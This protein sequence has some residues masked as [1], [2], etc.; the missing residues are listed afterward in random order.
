MSR[1][2][3]WKEQEALRLNKVKT[4]LETLFIQEK[5][6]FRKKLEKI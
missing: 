3:F 5:S 1:L 2:T 6:G 4:F